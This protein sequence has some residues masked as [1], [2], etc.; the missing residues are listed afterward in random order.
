LSDEWA[1]LGLEAGQTLDV[2]G[3]GRMLLS[4]VV[5]IDTGETW[6]TFVTPVK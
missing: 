5:P 1:G 3:T 4:G 6:A 2:R